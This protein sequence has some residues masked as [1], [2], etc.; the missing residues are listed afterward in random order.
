M[1]LFIALSEK[2]HVRTWPL[3]LLG[4]GAFCIG[5]LWQGIEAMFRGLIPVPY[6]LRRLRRYRVC[7]G[8]VFVSVLCVRWF[9]VVSLVSHQASGLLRGGCIFA[10]GYLRVSYSDRADALITFLEFRG[11]IATLEYPV[12]PDCGR[13]RLPSRKAVYYTSICAPRRLPR[14]PFGFF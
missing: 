10:F 4:G 9:R 8:F 11:N 12:F 2:I 1:Y 7:G 6:L 5:R 14:R 3:G 13:P